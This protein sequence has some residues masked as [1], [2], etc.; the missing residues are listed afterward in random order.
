MV[1]SGLLLKS[2]SARGA[3]FV[4]MSRAPSD[5]KT[6]SVAH[7]N[8]SRRVGDDLGVHFSPSRKFSPRAL[9]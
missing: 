6:S 8:R 9:R 7:C 3:V 2:H 5:L 4:S 1:G